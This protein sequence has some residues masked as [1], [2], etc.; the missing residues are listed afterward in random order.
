MLTDTDISAVTVDDTNNNARAD[1]ADLTWASAGG[2][3]NNALVKLLV[4]YDNDT[5][6]GTDSNLIPLTFHDFS[7]TTNGNDLTAVVNAQGYHSA[8]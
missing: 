1:F 3:A 6:G 2:T 8:S 4:C 7:T 5:T